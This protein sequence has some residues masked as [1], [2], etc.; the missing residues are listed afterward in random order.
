MEKSD[1][2]MA[3]A[4]ARNDSPSISFTFI[5]ISTQSPSVTRYAI[6]RV[7]LDNEDNELLVTKQTR[8]NAHALDGKYL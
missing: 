6:T 8:M 5:S 7:S 4:M 3:K 2:L 1:Q